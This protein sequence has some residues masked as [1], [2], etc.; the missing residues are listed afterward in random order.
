[1]RHELVFRVSSADGGISTVH[2]ITGEGFSISGLPERDPMMG[3]YLVSFAASASLELLLA[4]RRVAGARA[5]TL[6]MKHNGRRLT[7]NTDDEGLDIELVSRLMK[8]FYRDD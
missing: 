4:L 1:M 3:A 5:F 2:D 7:I 6:A 8:D